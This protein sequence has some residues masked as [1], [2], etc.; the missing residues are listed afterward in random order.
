MGPNGYDTLSSDFTFQAVADSAS[1]A[2]EGHDLP[3][4]VAHFPVFED[5]DVLAFVV[6]N[7]IQTL[8]NE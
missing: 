4:L 7:D 8:S 2:K 3:S 6:L 1:F 5:D